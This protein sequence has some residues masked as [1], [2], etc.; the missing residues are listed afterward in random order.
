MKFK[1][2]KKRKHRPKKIV[3]Q[4]RLA[5]IRERRQKLSVRRM[6]SEQRTL[7]IHDQI[8]K[9]RSEEIG[10]LFKLGNL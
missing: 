1:V 3:L 7:Q 8:D 4:E 6:K 10:V 9:L 2:K 5:R